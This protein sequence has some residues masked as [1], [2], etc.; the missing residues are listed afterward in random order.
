VSVPSSSPAARRPPVS[1]IVPAHNEATV[2]GRC[3]R[4]L[5]RALSAADEVIVVCNG[6]TDA[7]A[8]VARAALPAARVEELQQASKAAALNHGDALA[9]RFPRLYVDAD[10]VLSPGSLDALVEALAHGVE[11]VAPA[12]RYDLAASSR[13][14]RAYYSIW[15]QLPSVAGDTVGKGVYGL[16]AAGRA[17]FA[18]FPAVLA[19]DHFVRDAVPPGRRAV[20]AAAQSTVQAPRTLRAVLRR[21]TRSVAGNRQVD[22]SS[23]VARRRARRRRLEWLGVIRRRPALILHAPLFVAV[24]TVPRLIARLRGLRGRTPGWD[25]DDTSRT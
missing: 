16:S 4:A 13:A 25:R 15:A 2:I 12:A 7:T 1:V 20:V 18:A 21:K 23:P 11:L 22:R 17:R 14:V 9:T 19:D 6:C 24:S 10:V 5:D 3:L 8:R